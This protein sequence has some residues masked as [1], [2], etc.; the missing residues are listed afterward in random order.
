MRATDVAAD[1]YRDIIPLACG[2][3]RFPLAVADESGSA[4]GPLRPDWLIAAWESTASRVAEPDKS[5]TGLF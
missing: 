5:E 2:N 3:T 1:R 4:T